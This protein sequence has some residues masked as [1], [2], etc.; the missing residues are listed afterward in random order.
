MDE[1][2]KLAKALWDFN[3]LGQ[4]PEKADCIVALGNSDVRTAHAAADLFNK[5]FGDVLVTTG[6]FGR[7]TKDAFTKPEAQ[8]FADEA[9]KFG[10]PSEKI[11]IEDKS[12]NT[13]DN[14]RFTKKLLDEKGL[15]PKSILIVTK[16]YMERRAFTTAQAVW[17]DINVCV[18]SPVLDFES[19][20]NESITRDLL[21]NMVVGDTQ[22]LMIFSEHNIISKQEFSSELVDAYQSL[23]K[24]G[25]NKQIILDANIPN[26]L[27][28]VKE[29]FRNN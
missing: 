23:V 21:I 14:I 27:A 13:F 2:L 5:G 8:I 7:L 6:G 11:I 16:P 25:Y 24:L 3:V 12:T 17:P 18:T 10:V 26:L 1:A 4:E 9:M 22:R 15:N 28:S 19:Y 20:P 29:G